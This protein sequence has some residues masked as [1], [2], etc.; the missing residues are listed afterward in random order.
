MGQILIGRGQRRLDDLIGGGGRGGRGY[1]VGSDGDLAELPCE[2]W[3]AEA[4]ILLQ[5]DASI[6]TEQRTEDCKGG[7]QR[8][9]Q[10]G[11]EPHYTSGGQRSTL[12]HVHHVYCWPGS[13]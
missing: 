1:G 9:D 5:A 6:L 7:Q 3:R 12:T 8:P 4:A 2:V 10:T 11:S 13:C